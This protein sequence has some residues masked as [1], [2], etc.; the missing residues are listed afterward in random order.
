MAEFMGKKEKNAILRAE[1]LRVPYNVHGQQTNQ[2]KT[3]YKMNK[4]I[5][6]QKYEYENNKNMKKL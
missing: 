4:E 3:K 6:K 2:E 1:G 5:K